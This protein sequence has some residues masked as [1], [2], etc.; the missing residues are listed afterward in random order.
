[1]ECPT[2]C[3]NESI[4]GIDSININDKAIGIIKDTILSKDSRDMRIQRLF[5]IHKLRLIITIIPIIVMVTAFKCLM[6]SITISPILTEKE[7]ILCILY[8]SSFLTTIP[9]LIYLYTSNTL[10]F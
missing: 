4:D 1:M 8:F 7:I 5:K 6:D 10:N 9:F 3:N 2:S